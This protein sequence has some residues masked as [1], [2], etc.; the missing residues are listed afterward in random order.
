MAREEALDTRALLAYP[1][2]SAGGL[3][4]T[5]YVSV[6]SDM[7]AAQV[8]ERIREEAHD[9]EMIYYIYVVDRNDRL[10]GVLSLKELIL[11][12]PQVKIDHISHENPIALPLDMDQEDVARTIANYD[13]LALPVV[14]RG[15]K[16]KG[17]ITVD[18]V[19]DVI[20]E[21]DT[22]DMYKF[23]AAGEHSESY[24][25]M[26]LITIARNRFTWLAVLVVTGFLSGIIMQH[27]AFALRSVVAL[28]F[29][30]PVV[31]ATAG[32][33]GTQAAMA[34]VRGLAIGELRMR[35]AWKVER[36]ELLI[37]GILG[38]PL[39]AIALVRALLLE[40]SSIL[41]VCVGFSML[42]TI[43]ASTFLGSLLP[44]LCKRIKLDPAVVSGPLIATILDV[45]SL[46]VYFTIS[47]FFLGL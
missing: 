10:L 18:D 36:K 39:S 29:Y 31:T 22:E 26:P 44:I 30:V 21:E 37:G 34:V 24:L 15:G 38:V 20:E 8:L 13:F 28:A 40:G 41:G 6:K 3:M 1:S 43:I 47:T 25:K 7:S 23:G 5:E 46:V 45:L 4:T 35:D 33:A 14:D 17:I 32:N 12:S 2:T 16:L 27:Y 11:A 9:V 42:L 19:I